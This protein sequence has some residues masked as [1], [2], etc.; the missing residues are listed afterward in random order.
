MDQLFNLHCILLLSRQTQYT[1]IYN[2]A[3]NIQLLKIKKLYT[4]L[5]AA[6]LDANFPTFHI[7]T[8]K[9]I[10]PKLLVNSTGCLL[11]KGE[12]RICEICP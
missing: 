2:N 1:V 6:F 9:N 12:I 7:P 4:H 3:F 8:H 11:F 5:S 10:S